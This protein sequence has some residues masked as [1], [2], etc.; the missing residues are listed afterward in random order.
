MTK[1]EEMN[2][3]KNDKPGDAGT[4]HLPERKKSNPVLLVVCICIILAGSAVLLYGPELGLPVGTCGSDTIA[5]T[6]ESRVA[7]LY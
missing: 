3:R 5:M 2:T 4:V 6:Y 1:T 7:G